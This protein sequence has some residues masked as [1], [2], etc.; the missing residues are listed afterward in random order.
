MLNARGFPIRSSGESLLVTL[1]HGNILLFAFLA[2][3]LLKQKLQQIRMELNA[4][5]VDCN[6]KKL[7]QITLVYA[8]HPLE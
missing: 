2:Y 6:N 4:A 3:S 7:H 8:G 1:F 5:R